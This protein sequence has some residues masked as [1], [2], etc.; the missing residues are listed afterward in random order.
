MVFE[1]CCK[2]GTLDILKEV[3]NYKWPGGHVDNNSRN[4]A[5]ILACAHGQV[6]VAI[7]LIH[8][9]EKSVYYKRIDTRADYYFNAFCEACKNGHVAVIKILVS[10]GEYQDY[11]RIDI[12]ACQDLAFRLACKNNRLD[13]AK[14]LVDL[15]ENCG[16]GRVN[17]HNGCDQPLRYALQRGNIEMMTWII[18]LCHYHGY[19]R[20]DMILCTKTTGIFSSYA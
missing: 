9:C 18:N 15:G 12:H 17:I 14:V 1:T 5:F 4:R 10:L 13:V 2:F 8:I 19:G 20:I 6:D 16:Y 7:W 3:L 11:E